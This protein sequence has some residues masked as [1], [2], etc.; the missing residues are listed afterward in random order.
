MPCHAVLF[1][2]GLGW[3]G[4]GWAGLGCAALRCTALRC[5]AMCYARAYLTPQTLGS[6]V[7]AGLL[8]R[9]HAAI[10]IIE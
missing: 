2:A 8:V 4:L 7:I 6:N 3:A 9:V 10:S 1:W 5:A